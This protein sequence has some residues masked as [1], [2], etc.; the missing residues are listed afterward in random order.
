MADLLAYPT[1]TPIPQPVRSQ[2]V[3]LRCKSRD[4]RVEMYEVSSNHVDS[5]YKI[6]VVCR[7]YITRE[8][9]T[10]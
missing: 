10:S 3:R 2:Q 5:L 9:K 8:D 4:V 1:L 7:L 6:L